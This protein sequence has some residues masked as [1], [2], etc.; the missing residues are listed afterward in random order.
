L[1]KGVSNGPSKDQSKDISVGVS[2]GTNKCL[3]MNVI[4]IQV[5]SK[6]VSM[7]RVKSMSKDKQR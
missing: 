6:G 4:V 1:G 5:M 3:S 2:K 7:I